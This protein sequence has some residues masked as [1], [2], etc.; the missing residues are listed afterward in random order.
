M[1]IEVTKYD[2]PKIEIGQKV[3]VTIAGKEYEGEVS[4]INKVAAANSQGT[5]VVGAEVHIK[6]P[7]EDIFLGVEAKLVIHTA[8]A[9]N[10][11][12]VPVEIV[13][14]DKMC[15]RDSF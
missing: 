10:V 13:N 4:K 11:L 14:A 3:D 2:L 5:P 6:N 7:D 15:I 1:G 12:T 8:S 9:E